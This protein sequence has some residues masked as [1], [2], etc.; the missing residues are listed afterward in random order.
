MRRYLED[1]VET[2]GKDIIA[3]IHE[4]A[5]ALYGKSMVHI[6][7]THI[8]GGVAEILTSL[9]PLLNDVGID[10][11]WRILRGTPDFFSVTKKFHN[12]LQ[13]E[14]INFTEW[15]RKLYVET[16]EDFSVYAHINHDCVVVHDPQPL[17]LTKFYRKRQPWVWRLHIDLS[18][19]HEATWEFLKKFVESYD[20][21]VVS[22]EA[23]LRN[24]LPVEQRIIRPAIDPLSQKN[25]E[26]SEDTITK[27]LDKLKVPRDKP[28]LLQ[29]SRF[30]KWKDPLGVID[31]FRLVKEVVDCRLVLCGNTASDDPEGTAMFEEITTKGKDLIENNDL[32]LISGADN[33]A[34]NALQRAAAVVIQKSL[35]EG[36]G[37]TVVEALWKRKAVVASRVGGIPLQISDVENGYL[38]EP[39][40]NQ[41]F[42]DKIVE[43]LQNPDLNEEVGRRAHESVRQ[44]FLITRLLSDYLHLMKDLA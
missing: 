1:Y 25:I 29:V 16:N 26:I 35:R 40:D 4:R 33:I 31:V 22:S 28:F 39:T 6:N 18:H 15:K 38:I 44:D 43:V 13:G 2:V 37:L 24:D 34:V 10:A 12:A 42:A 5:R 14:P 36:F 19:P 7:S 41:G 30:D 23:Y 32:V 27:Y 3:D 9:L 20:V 8:G 11:D 17:P 21:V